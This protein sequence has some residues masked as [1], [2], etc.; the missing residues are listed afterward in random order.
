MLLLELRSHLLGRALTHRTLLLERTLP[1]S[2]RL[3]E[4]GAH[5]ANHT[6]AHRAHLFEGWIA[7][8]ELLLQRRAQAIDLGLGRR[9]RLP[10]LTEVDRAS[11]DLLRPGLEL[12]AGVRELPF[13]LLRHLSP[14]HELLGDLVGA[15]MKRP[16]L[17]LVALRR[18]EE[19]TSELQ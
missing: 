8:H 15:A 4:L 13:E 5:L 3:F 18:S 9:E 10:R 6:L 11:I 14:S 19:H 12:V 16:H 17:G 2:A 7:L 1:L